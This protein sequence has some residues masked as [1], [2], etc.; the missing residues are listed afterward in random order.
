MGI[1]SKGNPSSSFLDNSANTGKEAEN[2]P[3]PG[4]PVLATGGLVSQSPHNNRVWHIFTEPGSIELHHGTSISV[5]VVGG[6][7]AGGANGGGGGGA[8]GI[9]W[10]PSVPTGIPA[11][12]TL[13]PITATIIVGDGGSGYSNN[14]GDSGS[15][16]SFNIRPHDTPPEAAPGPQYALV[17]RGGGGGGIPPN[18][19]GSGPAPMLQQNGKPGGSGGG[20]GSSNPLATGATGGS[21]T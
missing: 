20:A 10:A 2:Q 13:T 12:G 9:A 6:G 5:L 14:A 4:G 7:G 18:N 8:G 11:G 19:P 3:H 15:P 21:T 1:R 17:G 16:S